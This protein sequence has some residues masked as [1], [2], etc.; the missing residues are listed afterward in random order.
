MK[1]TFKIIGIS[2]LVL[3]L[4][5]GY[6]FRKTIYYKEIGKRKEIRITNIKLLNLINK[7]SE[8]ISYKIG[9]T[10]VVTI[11]NEI[12][13]Q[14]LRFTTHK[15]SYNPNELIITKQ[16]NC[17]GYSAMFNSI[18]NHIIRKEKLNDTFEATHKVGKLTLFGTD[19]HKFFKSSFFKTHDFNTI[20]NLKT[21][22][23]ISIDPSMSDYLRIK[24]VISNSK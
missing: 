19:L 21:G 9:L 17:I 18:T 8:T 11:A 13:T 2:L 12:T 23:V 14:E 1:K 20:K 4:F 22:E 10:E 7:K 6:I 16:A 3:I 24:R 5:R 15:V